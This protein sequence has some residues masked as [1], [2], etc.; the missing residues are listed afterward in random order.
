MLLPASGLANTEAMGVAVVL[1]PP[2]G[3]VVPGSQ[4]AAEVRVRNTGSV[5]DHLELD[6]IGDVAGWASVEPPSVNLLPGEEA[7]GRVVFEPPRSPRVLAGEVPYA[8]RVMSREDTAGSSIE[9]SV[10]EVAPFS[11]V[12]GEL[13]PRTSTG[14]RAGRHQLALDNLGNHAQLV[15]VSA[16]DPDR[17]LSFRISPANLTLEPGTAVFVRVQVRP[18]RTFWLGPHRSLPFQVVAVPDGADPVVLPASVLQRALLPAWLPKALAVGLVAAMAAVVL[19]YALLKPTVESTAEAV[20]EDRTRE[21]AEAITEASTR[22][23]EAQQEAAAAEQRAAEAQT[24]AT[25]A[26]KQS[27]QADKKADK[28]TDDAIKA[29]QTT[30]GT[31]VPER[32]LDFRVTTEVAPAGRFDDSATFIPPPKRVVWVSDLVLQNPAGD[33]GVLRIQRGDVVLLEFGLE[34]FRDLDYHFIQPAQFT[35]E[36]PVVVAV[37]CRNASDDCTPSVYFSGQSKPLPRNR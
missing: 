5:V 15:S 32:A 11:Q 1:Q 12:A 30:T 6:L 36:N 21:L 3:P 14:R 24:K 17:L 23:A 4:A 29:S 8:L 22:A 19:W 33:S 16:T 25:A 18:D 7:A 9:E 10:V 13:V 26:E 27:Q 34:N 2:S 35:T 28:V 20:A 37:D 31:L